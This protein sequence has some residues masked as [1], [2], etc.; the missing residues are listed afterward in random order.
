MRVLQ[1]PGETLYL[2]ARTAHAILNLEE[3]LSVTE[4]YLATSGLEDLVHGLLLGESALQPSSRENERLWRCAC[5]VYPPPPPSYCGLLQ[6]AV[7]QAAGQ[8]GEEGG[9]GHAGPGGRRHQ[10]GGGGVL[11]AHLINIIFS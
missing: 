9:P 2:P 11:L 3:N 5:M 7:L 6:V 8:R 4:N 10:G 1:R